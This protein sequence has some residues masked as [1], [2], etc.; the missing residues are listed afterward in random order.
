VAV[1]DEVADR[2]GNTRTVARASYVHPAVIRS[3]EAGRLH[4]WWAAGP[5]RATR[6]IDVEERRLLHLLRRARRSGL[7]AR[8]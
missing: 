5:G 7:G 2:L 1:V 8:P 4:E 3:F 6:W